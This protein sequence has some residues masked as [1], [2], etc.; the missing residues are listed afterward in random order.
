[1]LDE[2]FTTG[3]PTED[4][5][6]ALALRKGWEATKRGWPDFVCFLPDG[7]MIVVEVKP[8]KK[9]GSLKWLKVSQ[10]RVMEKLTAAGI[11]CFVSDGKVLEPFDA[12]RHRREP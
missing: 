7:E 2:G 8:R 4:L 11:R 5:F 12:K 1:M 9:D 6:S 10:V 3:N